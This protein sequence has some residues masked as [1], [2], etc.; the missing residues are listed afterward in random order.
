MTSN[1]AEY[2]KQTPSLTSCFIR[3]A[4]FT[5]TTTT[6]KEKIH[7]SLFFLCKFSQDMEREEKND[8]KSLEATDKVLNVSRAQLKNKKKKR[9]EDYY[10]QRLVC[11]CCC[12]PTARLWHELRSPRYS[13]RRCR[14]KEES[15]PSKRW[16]KVKKFNNIS[17]LWQSCINQS[18][19]R[20]RERERKRANKSTSF[21]F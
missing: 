20:C 14:R 7:N 19:S 5:T 10:Y 17:L 8:A 9:I 6:M 13:R 2:L 16:V 12:F 15:G 4:D 1:D 21:F 11:C 3:S 18:N